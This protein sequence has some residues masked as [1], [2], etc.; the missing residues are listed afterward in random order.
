MS[1]DDPQTDREWIM[2]ID[3]KVDALTTDLRSFIKETKERRRHCDKR[4]EDLE[5]FRIDHEGQEKGTS[6]T[7]AIVASA[8]ATAGVLISILINFWPKGGT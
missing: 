1:A 3:G 7:A 2:R 4:L 5:T 8:I 6:K